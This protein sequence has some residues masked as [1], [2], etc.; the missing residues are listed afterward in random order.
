[1]EVY[2]YV[3]YV[4][5][6]YP[7]NADKVRQ[8]DRRY[9]KSLATAIDGAGYHG[10]L[11]ATGAA[12]G[13]DPWAI[14][15]YLAAY[16][17]RMRFLIA[18]H[19][20]LLSPT[21]LAKQAVTLD[22]LSGGRVELN[23]VNGHA[24]LQAGGVHLQHDER[25]AHGDE[26]LGVLRQL[27]TGDDRSIDHQGKHLDIRGARPVGPGVHAPYPPIW[28]GGSSVQAMDLAAKHADV[29]ANWA[30]PLDR[31]KAHLAQFR[32]RAAL[33][34]RQVE[35]AMTVHVVIRDTEEQAWA[36]VNTMLRHADQSA[37]D[38]LQRVLSAGQ[39]EGQRRASS[40]HTGRLPRDARELE[41]APNVWTGY[42]LL[43]IG[44]SLA[45]VG[46]ARQVA[47]RLIEYHEAG[48]DKFI[49]S[50]HPL[51][52]EAWRVADELLP[53]LPLKPVGGQREAADRRVRTFNNQVNGLGAQR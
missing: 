4:D 47:D 27:L 18:V 20:S 30:E 51:P 12:G 19:P 25:Y 11:V 22:H 50:H 34:G 3:F 26:Y 37:V 35:T 48:V 42:G 45:F 52:E 44:S 29:Y 1:M 39:S 13:W 5:G 16:T 24:G 21:L 53:L 8:V 28:V 32:E 7:W 33:A 40:L 10:A 2:W 31:H 38:N 6:A 46:T 9:L 23:I 41:I 15:S 14:S 43:R 49:L 17:E 36:E